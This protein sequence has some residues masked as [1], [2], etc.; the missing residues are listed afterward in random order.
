[1]KRFRKLAADQRLRATRDEEGEYVIQGR[2]GFICEGMPGRLLW[3]L[4][5]PAGASPSSRLKLAAL[6]DP[7][8]EVVQEGDAE[9]IFEFDEAEL[10]H[11]AVRWCKAFRRRQLSPEQ[12][13]SN[14]ERLASF[15]FQPAPQVATR[16]SMQS[17]FDGVD[18]APEPSLHPE[19]PEDPRTDPV[20]RGSR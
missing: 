9:A 13:A 10:A 7:V 16:S 14:I 12:R 1:M 18:E 4:A 6:R 5:Y 15:R 19:Q 20:P 17:G 11:V 8:L 3:V 2:R